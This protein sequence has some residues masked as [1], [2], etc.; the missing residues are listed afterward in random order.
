M[1]LNQVIHYFK[2]IFQNSADEIPSETST[3]A[4]VE[5]E[6][7]NDC[8]VIHGNIMKKDDIREEADYCRGLNWKLQKWTRQP[9]L[10]HKTSGAIRFYYGQD[11]DPEIWDHHETGWTHDHCSICEWPLKENDNPEENEGYFS[12]HQWICKECHDKFVVNNTLL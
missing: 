6:V 3:Q 5:N 7:A 4:E 1:P 11:F 12:K 10:V 8:V 2:T 9:A